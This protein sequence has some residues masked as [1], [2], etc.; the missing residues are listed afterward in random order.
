MAGEFGKSFENP[1]IR[2]VC[3]CVYAA[4]VTERYVS[5]KINSHKKKTLLRNFMCAIP[6]DETLNGIPFARSQFKILVL[7]FE[8]K[9]FKLK[10]GY[11]YRNVSF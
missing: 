5:I 11:T 1:E 7:T 9:L 3:L 8:R 4:F 10:N 6:R 2:F